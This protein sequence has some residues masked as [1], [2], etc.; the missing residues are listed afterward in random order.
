MPTFFDGLDEALV[1]A[2]LRTQDGADET[3]YPEA[4]AYES[5]APLPDGAHF[6]RVTQRIVRDIRRIG[7]RARLFT[8]ADGLEHQVFGATFCVLLIL[9][10]GGSMSRTMDRRG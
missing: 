1:R 6:A 3:L 2:G 4:S 7:Y 5:A 8:S 10:V 9:W